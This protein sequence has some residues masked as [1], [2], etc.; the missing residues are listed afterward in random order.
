MFT[1]DTFVRCGRGTPPLTSP[2]EKINVRM[3][4]PVLEQLR[5]AGPGWQTRVNDGM[6]M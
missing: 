6:A 2:K 4:A 3:D 5:T 1:G